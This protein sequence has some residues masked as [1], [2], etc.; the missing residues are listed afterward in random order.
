MDRFSHMRSLM[1]RFPPLAALTKV[2]RDRL[3]TAAQLVDIP[4]GQFVFRGEEDRGDR[5]FLLSGRVRLAKANGQTRVI[6]A[7]QPEAGDALEGDSPREWDC[8]AVEPVQVIR[9]P[10]DLIYVVLSRPRGVVGFT[11]REIGD[12]EGRD[13]DAGSNWMETLLETPFFRDMPPDSI[14]NLLNRFEPMSVRAGQKIIQQGDEGRYFY[15]L[16]RGRAE[17]VR[18]HPSGQTIRLAERVPGEGFGEEALI[19]GARRNA[20]VRMLTDGEVQ[21]LE[22][23]DFNELLRGPVVVTREVSDATALIA[24]QKGIWMDVRLSD[25]FQRDGLPGTVNLPLP[26]LRSRLGILAKDRPIVAFCDTGGRSAVAVYLLRERGIEAWLLEGG[27]QA[28]RLYRENN[29]F[30]SVPPAASS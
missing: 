21:K 28:L 15:V 1:E 4:A 18:E 9:V 24:A 16:S 17:V 26:L 14:F 25:E 2:S 11:V 12:G 7:D 10:A 22:A 29:A 27:L 8:R 23:R 13:D 19:S 3:A 30:D 5:H 20:T 6:A